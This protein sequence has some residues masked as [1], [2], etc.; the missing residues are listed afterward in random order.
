MTGPGHSHGAPTP[1]PPAPAAS[2]GR[3]V[4]TL[5]GAGA[6]AGA[7]IVLVFTAT[8]PR[9]EAHR[10]ARLDAAV[11]EVLKAPARYDTLWVVDGMLVRQAPAGRDPADGRVFHGFDAE[12]RA[13]GYA[14]VGQSPGFADIIRVIFGY[15]PATR[16]L[17]GMKVLESKETPGLGDRIELDSGFVN[18]FRDPLTPL[19]GVKPGQGKGQPGEIDMITGATI[20]SRTVIKA[21]NDALARVGPALE[22]GEGATP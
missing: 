14:V 10:A 11:Q 9:I 21:I 1:P 16:T 12:G 8:A 19:V 5:G 4:V 3:L 22:A 18:Q 17:L 7:L 2:A 15:D 20:S 6:M 13:I